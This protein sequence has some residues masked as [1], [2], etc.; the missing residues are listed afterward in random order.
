MKTSRDAKNS[1]GLAPVGARKAPVGQTHAIVFNSR[2]QSFG[3]PL[4]TYVDPVGVGMANDVSDCLLHYAKGGSC[5]L[6]RQPF[7][8]SFGVQAG[9][10]AQWC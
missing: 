6:S 4:K 10:N 2:G 3:R 7:H 8:V 5:H 9:S 1:Q